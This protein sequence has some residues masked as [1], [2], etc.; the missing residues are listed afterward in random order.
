MRMKSGKRTDR[1]QEVQVNET[2]RT[3]GLGIGVRDS[4][5]G[6]VTAGAGTSGS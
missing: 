3:L 1:R 2:R 4:R 5:G 6:G